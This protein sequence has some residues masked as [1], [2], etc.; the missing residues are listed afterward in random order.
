MCVCVLVRWVCCLEHLPLMHGIIFM[1]VLWASL[2]VFSKYLRHSVVPMCVVRA[3]S[4]PS[5]SGV[6]RG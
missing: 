1:F 5:P 6:V 4:P 2:W 3:R